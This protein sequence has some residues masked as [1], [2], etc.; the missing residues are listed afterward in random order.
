MSKPN[1]SSHYWVHALLYS[2]SNVVS[3]FVV[4]G[5]TKASFINW[6]N[7]PNQALW[8]HDTYMKLVLRELEWVIRHWERNL[9]CICFYVPA[10]H[11]SGPCSPYGHCGNSQCWNPGSPDVLHQKN[12][13]SHKTFTEAH[14]HPNRQANLQARR[15]RYHLTITIKRAYSSFLNLIFVTYVQI[16][17]LSMYCLHVDIISL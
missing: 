5:Y 10:L 1:L 6:S 8:K 11:L 3:T 17:I 4:L 14:S 9:S 13:D 16:T 12:S 2:Q 7:T 15:N